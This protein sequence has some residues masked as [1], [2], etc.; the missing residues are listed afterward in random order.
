MKSVEKEHRDW[1]CPL[2]EMRSLKDAFEDDH[3]GLDFHMKH[4]APHYSSKKT[5]QAFASWEKEITTLK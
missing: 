1:G 3:I 2:T 4:D 5:R